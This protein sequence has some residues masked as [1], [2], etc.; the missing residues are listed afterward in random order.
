MNKNND[1]GS[2]ENNENSTGI[3][4][5][6]AVATT[7]T[8]TIPASSLFLIDTKKKCTLKVSCDYKC[9]DGNNDDDNDDDNLK[10][11]IAVH[12]NSLSSFQCEF[13]FKF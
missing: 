1:D 6:A 2:N 4:V 13:N 9:I 3:I 8:A 11:K 5:T 7:T 12:L 10:C